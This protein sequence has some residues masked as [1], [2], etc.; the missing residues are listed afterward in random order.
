M[1]FWNEFSKTVKG[2][3]DQT[4][5]GAEK[6]TGIAKIKYKISGINSKIDDCYKNIG[7][8]SYS[9]RNGEEVSDEILEQFC[10]ELDELNT[11]LDELQ[12]KLSDFR[13]CQTCRI[14]GYRVQK[15]L[16]FCPK[17]GEKLDSSEN[18]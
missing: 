17:C 12:S 8:L 15:G 3:A 6:L 4:V 7:Q 18:I 14:C 11:K 13:E 16:Y 5:K 2:A 10:V 9:K 1:E